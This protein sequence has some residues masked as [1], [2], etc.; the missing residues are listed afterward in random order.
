M[1]IGRCNPLTYLETSS[2]NFP[3]MLID[4]YAFCIGIRNA[5]IGTTK[6]KVIIT[7]LAA[8]ISTDKC[9]E[10]KKSLAAKK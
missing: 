8:K 7:S 2:R 3:M 10:V 1:Y 5:Y 6:A 9:K 4:T